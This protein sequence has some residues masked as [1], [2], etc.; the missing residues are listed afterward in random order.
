MSSRFV[1][2]PFRE[3]PPAQAGVQPPKR[4]IFR[5]VFLKGGFPAFL[6]AASPFP[7]AAEEAAVTR[8]E[9]VVVTA[10]RT[11][12]S[13]EETLASVT[14]IDR[15]EIER[16]QSQSVQDVLRGVPGVSISNSGGLGKATSVFL[17]G[18]NADHVLVL[19]DGVRAG[20]ATLGTTSF[21]DLPIDQIERIEIVRGPRASLYGSEAIGGVIQIFT[22]KGGG[23]LKPYLSFGA[24]SHSMYKATGGVSGGD[25]Q[26][27]YSLNGSRL[28]TRGFNACDGRAAS[29]FGGCFTDEPD[30]DGYRNTSGSARAGYRFDNGLEIEGNLLHAEGDNEFDGGF[31]NQSTFVQ[32]MLGGSLKYSP[33]EFWS[34]SL[35]AGRTLDESDSLKNGRFTGAFNTQRVNTTWQNDFTLA[36]GN[37]LTV[38]LDYYND[39]VDSTVDFAVK[40][41]DDKAGFTQYQLS[42]GGFDAVLGARV[43]DNEQFGVH[44]TGNAA[45]GYLFDNGVRVTASWGNA[46]KAPTFNELFFPGFGNPN[47]KPE[48]SE[49]WELGVNG[50][51]AGVNWAVNGFFTRADNFIVLAFDPALCGPPFFFC[52]LNLGKAEWKGLEA[53]AST[54]LWGFDLAA[55]LSLLD[56]VDSSVTT[57]G[58]TVESRIVPPR[59]PQAMFRF[60]IDRRFGRFKL[61][62]TVNGEDRRFDDLANEH[63]LPGFVT[64]DLRAAVELYKGLSL[65][66]RVANLLDE[67]YETARF[68]HQDDRN[69][70]L[71][72]RYQPDAL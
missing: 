41:R 63:R 42:L 65:E 6:L 56:R 30:H 46:F 1:V 32:Q 34:T 20:S 22:R 11:E 50:H 31:Q 62:A 53:Q 43:D 16:R 17:R 10:T 21:Q 3:F 68:F 28:E 60:D 64:V 38:G 18:A 8:F 59:R 23:G 2:F 49:S 35:R 55:N 4:P 19:I 37:L 71:T 70:L 44:P 33:L 52:P 27:W 24:G 45:L 66:G 69:F 47:L 72:L 36:E 15:A 26:A 13:V 58:V 25:N 54:R 67:Q 39:Q 14:V 51:H 12:Q 48:E 5:N 40:S 57:G 9:P 7:A 61:G 29:L